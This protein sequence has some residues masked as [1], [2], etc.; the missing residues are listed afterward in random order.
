MII[1]E[2]IL[3]EFKAQVITC[4]KD[5]YIFFEDE[6]P[7]YYYQIR[8]GMIKMSSFSNDGQEFIQGVFYEGQSFGEPA[9]FGSFPYPSNAIAMVE[10][11]VYRLNISI[12]FEILRNHFELHKKFNL[13]LAERLRYKS[14]LLKEISSYSPDHVILTLLRYIRERDQD[15]QDHA[16]VIPYT[17]QQIAD[18]TGLRVET[19]IR[20]IKKL[21]LEKKLEIKDHKIILA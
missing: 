20:T 15:V 19:V 5:E 8:S 10:S 21:Q 16:F 14:T 1:P 18:M 3:I 11:T 4:N 6:N 2:E 17:R 9:I 12:F 13:I 7:K